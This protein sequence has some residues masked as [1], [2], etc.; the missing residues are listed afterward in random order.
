MQAVSVKQISKV[1]TQPIR[2][3]GFIPFIK[4][5][6]KPKFK[7]V[8]AVDNISF[9]IAPGELVGFI[10]PNG[11]GKST[12]LKMLS[13]I[14]YP[15]SGEIEVLGYKPFER[16]KE[17]LMQIGMVFGQKSQ[18]AN[19][20]PATLSF[21][22]NKAIFEVSD[23]DYKDR[24]DQLTEL[25]DVKKLLPVQVRKLSLGE[26]MK[27]ELI[28]SIL[29]APKILFLDE[30][31]IGLDIE[32]QKS[33]REF[34]KTYNRETGATIILTSH[35]MEDVKKLCNRVI[36]IN[37][38]KIVSD[39]SIKEL[40]EKFSQF[41]YIDFRLENPATTEEISQY[42]RIIH[43]TESNFLLEIPK[44][45]HAEVVSKI[46][47]KY[48]VDNIDITEPSLEDI[49]ERIYKSSSSNE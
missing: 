15:S 43:N 8:N 7:K 17:F 42:G 31:T 14:L 44:E 46:L 9:E 19:D 34:L 24:L 35:N 22:L 2:K 21:E 3:N 23:K 47:A 45:R 30:P 26:R 1:F 29:H 28:M 5:V 48:E 16:K 4:S 38:G 39:S 37:K 32:A 12:T 49:I 20:L 10:G 33:L 41:K 36:I 13:G 6:L 18:L 11:A 25:L 40:Y 27:F